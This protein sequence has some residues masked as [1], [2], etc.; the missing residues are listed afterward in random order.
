MDWVI[1]MSDA[2]SIQASMS[3]QDFFTK[4]DSQ[5][6]QNIKQ[7]IKLSKEGEHST[8]STAINDDEEDQ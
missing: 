1:H 3:S 4:S 5:T 2:G 7:M 6:L 8:P